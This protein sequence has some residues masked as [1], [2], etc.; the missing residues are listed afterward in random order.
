MKMA[1]GFV[2]NGSAPDADKIK[3]QFIIKCV[4][5]T[6]CPRISRACNY[7]EGQNSIG[8]QRLLSQYPYLLNP[9]QF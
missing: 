8:V 3:V 4:L 6:A 5:V 1:K 9:P 7:K 2:E